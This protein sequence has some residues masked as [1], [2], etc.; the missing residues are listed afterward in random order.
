MLLRS[1]QSA[2]PPDSYA[3]SPFASINPKCNQIAFHPPFTVGRTPFLK[4]NPSKERGC[5]HHSRLSGFPLDDLRALRDSPDP[6]IPTR[7]AISMPKWSN[8][9]PIFLIPQDIS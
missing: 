2:I 5:E 1:H 4:L 6:K 9:F 3:P 7:R 8:Q